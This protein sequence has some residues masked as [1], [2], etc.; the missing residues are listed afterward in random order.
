MRFGLIGLGVR[1]SDVRLYTAVR[2]SFS[3]ISGRQPFVVYWYLKPTYMHTK[4]N[5]VK[6][7]TPENPTGNVGRREPVGEFH[8]STL[9][10]TLLPLG[11]LTP[12][13]PD[14]K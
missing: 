2:Q 8:R 7:P 3:R 14:P 11:T 12:P 4:L 1:V 5:I 10:P 6:Y 9:L 13:E